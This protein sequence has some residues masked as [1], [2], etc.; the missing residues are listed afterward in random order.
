MAKGVTVFQLLVHIASVRLRHSGG[1]ARDKTRVEKARLT[2]I[3]ALDIYMS[4]TI[5]AST[6]PQLSGPVTLFFSLPAKSPYAFSSSKTHKVP[7]PPPPPRAALSPP[8][9]K[10]KEQG[11]LT[12]QSK[13]RQ[14]R[15]FPFGGLKKKKKPTCRQHFLSSL[16]SL[17]CLVLHLLPP[18][19]LLG[20]L[21]LNG[22]VSKENNASA[23]DRRN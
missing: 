9:Q 5:S 22:Q 6:A 12:R 15:A 23:H 16:S 8:L 4:S 13:T 3:D 18:F 1:L 14:D 19:F 2:T 21:L 11:S 17:T 20:K 7:P 10:W